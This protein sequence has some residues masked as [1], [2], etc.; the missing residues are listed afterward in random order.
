MK[1]KNPKP[2]ALDFFQNNIA[3]KFY[4]FVSDTLLSL[5]LNISNAMVL[6]HSHLLLSHFDSYYESH[7]DE[8]FPQA[9]YKIS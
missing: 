3:Q 4:L 2:T 7:R 5:S 6:S 8:H 1:I 9:K